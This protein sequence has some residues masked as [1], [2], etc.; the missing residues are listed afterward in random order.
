MTTKSSVR[1]N[2]AKLFFGVYTVLH[3]EFA[4]QFSS[5]DLLSSVDDFIKIFDGAITKKI[6]QGPR[7]SKYFPSEDL[8]TIIDEHSWSL[9][10]ES[11]PYY[12]NDQI[13]QREA[14]FRLN[15][16]LNQ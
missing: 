3:K 5:D 4:E 8:C 15:N 13:D 10:S 7:K 11:S 16:L 14:E 6:I 12:W 2:N 1:R 9:V